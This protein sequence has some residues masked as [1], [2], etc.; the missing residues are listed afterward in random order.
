M[1]DPNEPVITEL[2]QA[3][4]TPL[5]P[6][7]DP[8]QVFNDPEIPAEIPTETSTE[9]PVETPE[10]P[11]ETPETPVET[12][13]TPVETPET[14]ET[15]VETPET[16]ETPV[17]TPETHET[18]ETPETPDTPVET[19]E[20]PETPVETPETPE[21][22][23]E[24][25]ETPETPVE[26]PETPETPVET[27]ETPESPVETPETPESPVETPETPET[28]VETPESPVE[29]PET[30]ETPV[31]TPEIPV[32]TPDTPETPPANVTPA[33]PVVA[34]KKAP[35]DWFPVHV[36]GGEKVVQVEVVIRVDHGDHGQGPEPVG[37]LEKGVRKRIRRVVLGVVEDLENGSDITEVGNGVKT[38]L[39][40]NFE[41]EIREFPE[42]APDSVLLKY[43]RLEDQENKRTLEVVWKTVEAASQEDR[44]RRE[45]LRLQF[46]QKKKLMRKGRERGKSPAWEKF[47]FLQPRWPTKGAELFKLYPPDE[48]KKQE[49]VL[50]PILDQMRGEMM[51]QI[52]GRVQQQQQQETSEQG[53]HAAMQNKNSLMNTWME[54]I[55]LCLA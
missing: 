49:A 20:T 54:Y 7:T 19:P 8:P 2:P 30:P 10:T 40:R 28:P 22:T 39:Q 51:Q 9:T 1:T 43:K 46:L 26:T 27:P 50:K 17:E 45:M 36:G 53:V 34:T 48:V 52:M 41:A 11:V 32:E 21:T 16:P 35:V 55:E 3:T 18:P 5:N 15:P 14:P 31:E 42:R 47:F 24:T 23:V 6:L 37:W 13:E 12:P 44:K 38:K 29:T 33:A 4:D 25:P